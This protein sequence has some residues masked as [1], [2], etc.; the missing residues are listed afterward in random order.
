MHASALVTEK[1]AFQMNAERPSL[2]VDGVRTLSCF[3]RVSQALQRRAGLIE[4]SSD[5]GGKVAGN[6]VG[7]EEFVQMRQFAG[8]GSHEIDAGAAVH[9]NV[10]EAGHQDGIGKA[11]VS[12]VGLGKVDHGRI[13]RNFPLGA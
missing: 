13:L 6:T 2:A 3:D 10:D 11:V 12:K 1:W 9:V 8:R 5:G 4:R 7:S